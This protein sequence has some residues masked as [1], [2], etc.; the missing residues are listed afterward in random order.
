M[1]R[2]LVGRY[3]PDGLAEFYAFRRVS[4]IV[5]GQDRALLY[6]TVAQQTAADKQSHGRWREDHCRA[7]E[8]A[9]DSE[10]RV[11]SKQQE[12]QGESDS[13]AAGVEMLMSGHIP[14]VRYARHDRSARYGCP[15]AFR[16]SRQIDPNCA[17]SD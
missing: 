4:R 17:R 14:N 12:V 7:E 6:W 8:S 15:T 3:H 13:H 10:S 16:T 11:Q 2:R 9:C 1:E 5:L